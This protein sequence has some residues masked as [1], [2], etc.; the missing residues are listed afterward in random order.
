MS[1]S[2]TGNIERAGLGRILAPALILITGLVC[3]HG[4][5]HHPF[6]FDDAWVIET[7]ENIRDL[8]DLSAIWNFYPTRFFTFLSL[9]FNYHFSGLDTFG[10]HVFNFAVHVATALSVYWLAAIL[11]GAAAAGSANASGE[12]LGAQAGYPAFLFPLTVALLFTA[13]PLQTEAVTYIW[14]RNTSLVTLFYLLSLSMYI[15]SSLMMDKGG[16]DRKTRLFFAG[17]VLFA[18]CAMFTKEVAVTLPVAIVLAEYYFI[19]GSLRNLGEKAVRLAA[20]L[21]AFFIVPAMTAFGQNPSVVHIGG[22]H[23]NMLSP[24]DYLLTQFNVIVKVYLK[25][26]FA[27]FGLNLDYDFPA[28]HSFPEAWVSFLVLIALVALAAWLF[29]RNRIASF[30]LVFFF[31][32]LSVE[33]SFFPLEDLVFEHR[34]YLPLAGLF[35]TIS[36]LLFLAARAAF[37]A[38]AAR[39]I[40]AVVLTVTACL[41]ALTIERNEVWQSREALWAD[42]IRKSP[43]KPRGYDSMAMV[44]L[45]QGRLDESEKWLLKSYSVN[46]GSSF[47]LYNLGIIQMKKGDDSRALEYM[48]K[49]LEVDPSYMKAH[50]AMGN[51]HMA[52]KRYPLAARHYQLALRIGKTESVPVLRALGTAY[53]L[54]G[55]IDESI[56]TYEKIVAVIPNDQ[57]ANNN[58]GILYRTKGNEEKAATHFRKARQSGGENDRQ[59]AR[60]APKR[61]TAPGV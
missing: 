57:Q 13:H 60:S 59:S 20:F 53:A 18:V 36:S 51:I 14:Q 1:I 21:P 39:A 24:V 46:N 37:H 6:Q 11:A 55:N 34:V 42:V 58:L 10:Y 48:E 8:S 28:A 41:S 38:N 45:E 49:A 5:F 7:N 29:N 32:T 43:G 16:A 17:S 31:L 47:V 3:Y 56:V 26:V 61:T 30:G 27:P 54:G 22:R 9:A 52:A 15:K 40:V 12:P 19:S 23:Y 2:E 50:L 44:F 35:M 25:L 4:A 33:S